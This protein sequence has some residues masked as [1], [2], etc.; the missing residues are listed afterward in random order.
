MAVEDILS[1]NSVDEAH[2]VKKTI[3]IESEGGKLC[4]G[5]V[6]LDEYKSINAALINNQDPIPLILDGKSPIE[7]SLKGEDHEEVNCFAHTAENTLNS[8]LSITNAETRFA[9]LLLGKVE[10]E[11]PHAT[12]MAFHENLSRLCAL[13]L[14]ESI[15]FKLCLVDDDLETIANIDKIDR[16]PSG[17][18][19]EY[20]SKTYTSTINALGLTKEE[21]RSQ[22]RYR[23]TALI[24]LNV[25]SVE[26]IEQDC[27]RTDFHK[28]Y[29]NRTYDIPAF[30]CTYLPTRNKA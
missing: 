1:R 7:L 13:G 2:K 24:P 27:K 3:A 28:L 12:A 4:V 5:I 16:T 22:A 15:N 8:I 25:K 18:M 9:Q 10:T 26:D 14:V 11:L 29:A 21:F 6:D 19:K 20:L 17:D 23:I 30:D